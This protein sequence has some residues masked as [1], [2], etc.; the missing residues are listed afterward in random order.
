MKEQASVVLWSL[1]LALTREL[2]N[3]SYFLSQDTDARMHPHTHTLM[4][5]RTPQICYMAFR[6][7]GT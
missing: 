2:L 7:P 5:A 6:K 3:P 1:T 4:R